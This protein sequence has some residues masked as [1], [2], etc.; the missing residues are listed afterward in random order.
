MK[1]REGEKF[2]LENEAKAS[3]KTD[4]R[5]AAHARSLRVE[6]VERGQ[7]LLAAVLNL[8]FALLGLHR[9]SHVLDFTPAC[10]NPHE[11]LD[12]KGAKVSDGTIP[13]PMVPDHYL[14]RKYKRSAHQWQC[15]QAR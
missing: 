1:E 4:A 14:Q 11:H 2:F 13:I 10:S 7:Q 9:R 15:R 5:D 12:L 6:L 3:R 8:F